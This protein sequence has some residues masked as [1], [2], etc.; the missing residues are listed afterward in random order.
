MTL[1]EAVDT[2]PVA[3][4]LA[5]LRNALGRGCAVLT[6]PPG[7]GK[8]TLVP[9][10]LRDDLPPGKHIIVVTPR[11]VSTRAAARRMASL[12]GGQVGHEVG[13]HVRWD[14]S[15]GRETRIEV[16][17][18]GVLL[19]RLESDPELP[20]THLVILDEFHERSLDADLLLAL[21]LQVQGSLRPDLQLLVMSATLDAAPVAALL[22]G[23]PVIHAEGRSYPVHLRQVAIRPTPLDDPRG[24]A[25]AVAEQVREAMAVHE[26]DLL[27]FLP[28]IRDLRAVATALDG[29]VPGEVRLLH[30][31]LRPE[32]QDAALMPGKGRRV[33]LATP[34]AQ[35]SLTV[36]GVT[37]V[38]DSGWARVARFD[39]ATGGNRL[40]TERISHA[41]AEQ[42]AGRAGRVAVGHCWRLWSQ[43]AHSRLPL[44]DSPEVLR[45][46]LSAVVLRAAGWGGLPALAL[47]DAPPVAAVDRATALLQQLGALDADG[48]ITTFGK[49]MSRLP[50]TPRLAA[51]L[52][53]ARA[54]GE[55]DAA[56][57][58]AAALDNQDGAGATCRSLDAAW[59]RAQYRGQDAAQLHRAARDLAR[60][61]GHTLT[62]VLPEEPDH[63]LGRL[64]A[65][66][67][68]ERIARQREASDARYLCADGGEV[69]L[70]P[71]MDGGAAQWLVVARWLPGQPRRAR[72]LAPLLEEEV[73]AGECA[74]LETRDE[75][76]WDPREAA[77]SACRVLR[78]GALAVRTRRL[79]NPDPEEVQRLLCAA[80]IGDGLRAL[81][82]TD[83]ARALQCRLGSLRAWR[84]DRWP[85]VD[86]DSLLGS[87]Q[88]WLPLWLSGMS[89]RAHLAQLDMVEVLRAMLDSEQ[90]Q[91]LSELAPTSVMVPSG[92]AVQLTY[93]GTSEPPVLAVKLQ[94][95]FGLESTP[96]VDGGRVAV[97]I[98]LL[99]PAG[100][101][102]QVTQDLASFWRHG[103]AEVARELRGRYP[104][105]P[106][107]VDPLS[108]EAS[109][110]TRARH[111]P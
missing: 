39:P 2:L 73:A 101:P 14:R 61:L 17:T 70:D 31:G 78:L 68:P 7:S 56:I 16:V 67:Y 6:A 76:V 41:A 85:A 109:M 87:A 97:R 91:A 43:D 102:L 4:A 32:A 63:C 86:N 110:R 99:S 105:H 107:P 57:R 18:E 19:R 13:Y 49:A 40:H 27:V 29:R 88:H 8:T 98:H 10:L 94:A 104:K 46:D 38:I 1:S 23:A 75:I 96:M 72:M 45:S 65:W 83:A 93:S 55:L 59:L 95:L 3:S 26:G 69:L 64:L 92:H 12:I 60:A 74:P 81:P 11:Q 103:Y 34:I 108:A 71:P 80:M 30:G 15:A 82:W 53:R 9:L 51:M 106:W 33:I 35:T 100:R 84:G 37:V 90:L 25:S 79:D 42:R 58:L 47:L 22:G 36:E 111:Q 50:L 44:Y 52:L 62:D 66:A 89:R 24:F 54:R 21:L 20:N 48:G 77:V 28:G 5:A